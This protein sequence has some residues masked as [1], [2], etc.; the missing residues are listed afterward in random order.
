MQT[1]ALMLRWRTRHSWIWIAATTSGR[2]TSTSFFSLDSALQPRS[3]EFKNW[4]VRRISRSEPS[5][6][7]L[8]IAWKTMSPGA[9]RVSCEIRG[10]K[11]T[12][13]KLST[14]SSML[15][16][17]RWELSKT[18]FCNMRVS[19]WVAHPLLFSSTGLG[20]LSHKRRLSAS[21]NRW[22]TWLRLTFP[23]TFSEPRLAQQSC[24]N[25]ALISTRSVRPRSW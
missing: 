25:I 16:I 17:S 15:I 8:L 20:I 19:I 22:K 21:K 11:I 2:P 24:P 3:A 18:S 5:F 14:P 10:L 13:L 1:I 4:F 12:R 9:L 23:K 7:N 6:K